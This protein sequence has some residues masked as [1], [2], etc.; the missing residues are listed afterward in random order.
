MLGEQPQGTEIVIPA[1]G[2]TGKYWLTLAGLY[3][4]AFLVVLSLTLFFLAVKKGGSSSGLMMGPLALM[5]SLIYAV[6]FF[7]RAAKPISQLRLRPD[8]LVLVGF[9]ERVFI[10]RDQVE[11]FRREGPA[12]LTLFASDGLVLTGVGGRPVVTLSSQFRPVAE[13]EALLGAWLSGTTPPLPPDARIEPI[14]VGPAGLPSG[15]NGWTLIWLVYSVLCLGFNALRVLALALMLVMRDAFAAQ[16]FEVGTA[17]ESILP[18]LGTALAMGAHGVGI[19]SFYGMRK[20]RPGARR[21]ALLAAWVILIA[22]LVFI[23]STIATFW[24]VSAAEMKAM[25]EVDRRSLV[26][27]IIGVV[28]F[29]LL[30]TSIPIVMIRLLSSDAAHREF[31][32]AA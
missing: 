2:F 1:R 28:L 3:V 16:G 8:G 25:T 9:F 14:G 17:A 15:W 13:L 27:P 18:F 29:R 32:G 31:D 6:G 12:N 19:W 30:M 4:L 22:C 24:S 21:A 26:A 5:I 11:A 10:R 20:R 7:A 23:V